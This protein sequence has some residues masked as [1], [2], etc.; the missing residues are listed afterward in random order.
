MKSSEIGTGVESEPVK[1]DAVSQDFGTTQSQ[2]ELYEA[3]K[4]TPP[5]PELFESY[6]V[7]EYTEA[8]VAD[9]L[10]RIIDDH[11][12]VIVA[13]AFFGDEGKGKTVDAVAHHPSCN[14]IARVNS[15]ENA[16][17]TVFDSHGR[18]LV[19][20]LAP[21]GLL[22]PNKRNYIG[23]ECVM[24]PV[25]FMRREVSQLVSAEIAYHDTL[26]IGNV[27]IVTPYHK[28]LDLLSSANNASTLKGMAPIH[29]S[30]V[31]KRGIRLDDV[32]NDEASLRR[33]LS[34]DMQTYFALLKL[35]NMSDEDVVRRCNCVNS[36]GIQRIADYVIDFARAADKVDYLVKLYYDQVRDN[37]AFPRRCDVMHEIRSTLQRGEKVLLEGPQSYWLSNSREKFW[38]STTSADTSAAGLLA[39][40]QLNFQKVRV[41]VI[42]VHKTPGSSR[43]GLG[44]CPSG[45]VP[46]DFF[47]SRNIKS[48]KDLPPNMCTDFDAIQRTFFDKAF[49]HKGDKARYNGLIE[50]IEYT[51]ASGTYN[52]GVAMAVASALHHNEF[53]AVTKKPRICGFFDCVMHHEVNA[54]Q[55]PYLSLSALDR[56]DD[57][58][59]IGLTIAYLYFDREDRK[60]N[61]NGHVY[62]N[63]DII[64]AGDPLPGEAA[65]LY[66]HP[67]IKLI[68]GWRGDPI[69]SAVRAK[70]APLPRAVC[71]TLA[72]IEHFTKCKILSIGNGP[73][74]HDIVYLRQ[75]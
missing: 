36:D 2:R 73:H 47:S 75:K 55:G 64:R 9:A 74:A 45:Y 34:N 56:G 72:A 50:P 54:V 25:S 1:R 63:G 13:G 67:I 32:F 11:D 23:P 38:T 68:D 49:A 43:V 57:Y 6:E 10:H 42:N 52:I 40:C 29:A 19:F 35:N 21:S 60:V 70:Y 20:N 22:A 17:H 69:G 18:K 41:V 14:C 12:V 62:R 28:L 61:V 53:G 33:R 30:K 44:A 27:H 48:L 7:K 51:D 37:P 16:G 24:D 4:N 5:L 65:L 26:F 15:G 3:I 46:Q 66:C 39:A 59:K 71:E 31:T 8:D 58:D